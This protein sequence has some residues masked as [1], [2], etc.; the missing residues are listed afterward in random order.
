MLT[1][2]N[3]FSKTENISWESLPEAFVKGHS[4]VQ[5]ASANNWSAYHSNENI[6][7]VVEAYFE[8]L[9]EYIKKNP[10]DNKP[11]SKKETETKPAKV[12]AKPSPKSPAAA[13]PKP[14]PKTKA[15]EKPEYESEEKE[16]I[17]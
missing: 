14:A 13:E 6:K 17:E 16:L 9:S 12:K 10:A 7:R 15:T 4:L 2:Q 8:K 5:G 1:I 3:Y 11:E